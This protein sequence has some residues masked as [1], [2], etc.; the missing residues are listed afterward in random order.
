[1]ENVN[2]EGVNRNRT[3]VKSLVEQIDDLV[4]LY[5]TREDTIAIA[6]LISKIVQIYFYFGDKFAE[7]ALAEL[8]KS[9]SGIVRFTTYFSLGIICEKSLLGENMIH[10]IN[11]FMDEPENAGVVRQAR[12]CGIYPN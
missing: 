6:S 1:M 2:M 12:D 7:Q 3:E 11:K 9:N 10:E 5:D 8:L 4:E